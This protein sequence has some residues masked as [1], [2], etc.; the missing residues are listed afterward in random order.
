MI[1]QDVKALAYNVLPYLAERPDD[2]GTFSLGAAILAFGIVQG[3]R[4][5]THYPL[6]ALLDLAKYQSHALI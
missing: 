3:L 6:L 4:I 2:G 5:V 1:R